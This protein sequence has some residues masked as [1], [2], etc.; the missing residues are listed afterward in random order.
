MNVLFPLGL[1]LTALRIVANLPKDGDITTSTLAASYVQGLACLQFIYDNHWVSGLPQYSNGN[2]EGILWIR[3]V[4]LTAIGVHQLTLAPMHYY[5]GA[6]RSSGEIIWFLHTGPVGGV[7]E[8]SADLLD[9]L[10]QLLVKRPL[11]TD[12]TIRTN[13]GV[14]IGAINFGDLGFATAN[15]KVAGK[16]GYL[17]KI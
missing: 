12:V 13:T 14:E 15:L 4:K 3:D 17:F 2:T 11:L 6:R 16:L 8:N 5:V 10:K 1:E 7:D 9:A